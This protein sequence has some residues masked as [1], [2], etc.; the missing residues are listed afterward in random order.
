MSH[1]ELSAEAEEPNSTKQV[2]IQTNHGVSYPLVGLGRV[3]QRDLMGN[4]AS[5]NSK[6]RQDRESGTTDTVKAIAS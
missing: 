4:P 3:K 5:R 6:N 1:E 2:A